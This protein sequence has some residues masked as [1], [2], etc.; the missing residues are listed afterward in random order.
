M[1]TKSDD[2]V[3][4]TMK[5]YRFLCLGG[6]RYWLDWRSKYSNKKVLCLL[7]SILKSWGFDDKC[8]SLFQLNGSFLYCA[9]FL[10]CYLNEESKAEQSAF[11][12]CYILPFTQK[13]L[14][15]LYSLGVQFV[16][17]CLLL[18]PEWDLAT[19]KALGL[20]RILPWMVWKHPK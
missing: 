3:W 12:Q 7:F 11:N 1:N 10:Y 5:L 8:F 15:L 13:N 4:A 16:S 9:S 17:V 20:P 14:A 2:L 6:I 18:R 19:E